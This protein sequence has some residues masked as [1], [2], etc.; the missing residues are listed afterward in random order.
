MPPKD[1]TGQKSGRLTAIRVAFIRNESTYWLCVCDCGNEKTVDR[2]TFVRR[3][4]I[5]C[6]CLH[7][8]I[9][10]QRLTRHGMARTPEYVAWQAMHQRCEN[11]SNPEYRNYGARGITVCEGWA[12]FD[13]FIIDMGMRPSP[14]HSIERA[15][16]DLGYSPDNCKWATRKEQNDNKRVTRRL[17]FNG[18]V[19]TL[20]QWAKDK[21]IKPATLHA[22]LLD[23][24][25]TTDAL[26]IPVG[27]WKSRRL[28]TSNR[29]SYREMAAD[30]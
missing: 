9:Q 13:V 28:R 4:N 17:R 15:D 8:E 3:P 21:G 11:P 24:W 14:K 30:V 6:G 27:K 29:I 5:S 23:G 20:T 22:R 16:N 26:T 10:R 18:R 7:K 2:S 25:T 1:L 19:K 12:T